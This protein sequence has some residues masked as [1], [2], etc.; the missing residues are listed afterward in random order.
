M[1]Y[2]IISVSLS[3]LTL[4]GVVFWWHC[5]RQIQSTTWRFSWTCDSCSRRR[6]QQWLGNPLHNFLLYG[7][8]GHN[9]G[10]E[11]PALIIQCLVISQLDYCM[12]LPLKSILRLKLVQYGSTGSFGGPKI[13]FSPEFSFRQQINVYEI[14]KKET[15]RLFAST[16]FINKFQNVCLYNI[17]NKITIAQKHIEIAV[18]QC[19]EIS[20]LINLYEFWLERLLTQL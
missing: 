13:I 1:L 12:G 20:I 6:W 5:P 18:L 10:L 11:L 7:S 15:R 17:C 16:L 3:S 4:H 2:A 9:P 14:T 19:P 8:C